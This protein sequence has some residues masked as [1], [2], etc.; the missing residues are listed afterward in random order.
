VLLINAFGYGGAERAVAIAAKWLR[1]RGHDVRLLALEATPAE[2]RIGAGIPIIR[3][4]SM[5]FDRAPVLKLLALP[6]L[7]ARLAAYIRRENVAA[8]MSHLFRANFVNILSRLVFGAAHRIVIVNHTR[9][10]RLGG[11][12]GSGRITFLLC[13]LL[14]PRADVVASVSKG[15]A[16]ECERMLGLRPGHS[17]VLYDPVDTKRGAAVTPDS[18]AA[19]TLV[20]IGRLVPLKRF[21]DLIEAFFRLAPDYPA[22]HLRIAG[23]GPSLA[24]LR[25]LA[26]SSTAGSRIHFPGR[27]DDP[28]PAF[29]GCRAFISTSETEGFGIAIVEALSAGVP[30]IASDCAYGPREILAPS[31]DS[32][33]FL[34]PPAEYEIAEYGILYPVGSV[35]ALEQ[36]IR[37]VLDDDEL[38]EKFARLGPIRAKCFSVDRAAVVYE[39]LLFPRSP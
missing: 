34:D 7:A 35:A 16:I 33:R 20:S 31:S 28:F 27:L 8:V 22:L 14:Y 25:R 5:R 13:R 10:S 2:M 26:S 30:V 4:S 24:G 12:G 11:E 19:E 38:S 1:Q 21:G 18:T 17:M 15:A 23:E 29:S 9:L 39:N 36:A 37:R 6:I 3:L 32:T